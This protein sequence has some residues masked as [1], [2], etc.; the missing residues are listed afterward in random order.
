MHTTAW[1]TVKKQRPV[2]R[3]LKL[4]LAGKR[5]NQVG[6]GRGGPQDDAMHDNSLVLN[7]FPPA[8]GSGM[9]NSSE[10]NEEV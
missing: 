4:F 2:G 3:S 9:L 10:D 5:I 1:P 6:L 7:G 8:S